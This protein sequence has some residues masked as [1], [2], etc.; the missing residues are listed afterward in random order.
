MTI[1]SRTLDDR[2][3]EGTKKLGALTP[4]LTTQP[5]T[6]SPP[7]G[8]TGAG[9]PSQPHLNQP[10][11]TP[12]VRPAPQIPGDTRSVA[13]PP[14]T[15]ALPSIPPALPTVTGS[16]TDPVYTPQ[17]APAP[18]PYAAHPP[19]VQALGPEAVIT[20][21]TSELAPG[22]S[23]MNPVQHPDSPYVTPPSQAV[24]QTPE[25]IAAINA[26]R[27]A[28][29]LPPLDLRTNEQKA[30]AQANV[31]QGLSAAGEQY[32]PE[33]QQ[34]VNPLVESL[35]WSEEQKRIN[36]ARKA[37]MPQP[38]GVPMPPPGRS[39][40]DTAFDAVPG[41]NT[42]PVV[43]QPNPEPMATPVQVVPTVEGGATQRPQQPTGLPTGGTV[44]KQPNEVGTVDVVPNTPPTQQPVAQ[45]PVAPE[46]MAPQPMAPQPQQPPAPQQPP[47]PPP[48]QQQPQNAVGLENLAGVLEQLLAN[49]SAFGSKEIEGL[50][51]N[52]RQQQEEE[53]RQARQAI[54][55]DAA[56][57]GVTFSSAPA[58]R[59][60]GLFDVERYQSQARAQADKDFA[61]QAALSR[62]EAMKTA[63]ASSLGFGQLGQQ[64]QQFK[65]QLALSLAEL[66]F[67]GAPDIQSQLGN[68]ASFG[69]GQAPAGMDPALWQMLGTLFAPQQAA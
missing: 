20:T 51:E 28:R 22:P 41:V 45:Q 60:G 62:D 55:A 56:K 2:A 25:Q 8:N 30:Q 37:A 3:I 33:I 69:L 47:Q 40:A 26:E 46:P 29:G 50:R 34:M 59:T 63:L 13:P 32:S 36:D 52:F 43:P 7:V 35:A 42:P 17:G 53:A 5:S 11:I 15:P 18:D 68:L 14:M 54:E 27:Q 1:R 64:D 6:L 57:R 10:S 39:P 23:A 48:A 49:P 44:I 31:K 58:T 67:R 4:T 9:L 16:R 65:D 12:V 61:A 66:G 21:Q 38:T 24:G 19:S